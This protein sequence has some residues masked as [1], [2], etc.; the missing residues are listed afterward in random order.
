MTQPGAFAAV[1]RFGLGARAGELALASGDPRGW[2]VAQLQATPPQPSRLAGLATG[3]QN[4]AQF[5]RSRRQGA[6]DA[7]RLIR[8]E[9]RTT[10]LR[11]AVART[12]TQIEAESPFR[13]RLVAF[14]SNHFTV[15]VQRPTLLGL[16]GAFEREAIRPNVTGK[17]RDMLI[18]ATRHPAMLVYLDNALSVGPNSIAGS[19]R[20]R[21]LNEN[22]AREILELHT[23]GVSGGYTQ[24]DVR[25][26]GRI[27]TG[28]SLG[29]TEDGDA[30]HY[31]FQRLIHEPGDK[32][33]LGM[34]YAEAGEDEGVAAL[35]ALAR[36]P[37]TA[38]H[39]ALK[40]ARHFVAD[41]PPAAVVSRL[42]QLFRDSDGDL[43]AL[44]R[45]VIDTPEAWA[46]PLA[47][48]KTPNEFVVSALRATG[49]AG[50]PERLVGSLRVLGQAPFAAPSPA[51]WPDI[52]EQWIG[53]E[54]V[55]RRAE[56]A[57][58]V[59]LRAERAHRP[60]AFFA[61]TIGPVADAATG[62]AIAGAPTA[63][64]G[65]ALVLASAEFQRR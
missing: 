56:W 19:R 52:A 25:E 21:G 24:D 51:G 18:A 11:E 38:T 42:A 28:W 43:A 16:A 54:S 61:A 40:F 30:G 14:W 3:A 20:G 6:A 58:A 9:F 48:V 50:D 17:F 59:A 44:S 15:S 46:N 22:L 37:A 7:Q 60:D 34:R 13:E 23:V 2:L 8:Q 65:L 33:L 63:A 39:I 64:E 31:K 4:M 27:L 35:T 26:F 32:V 47:K 49:F 41:Q 1:N 62:A 36:H 57:M 12:L 29:R 5:Q 10:Y 45:A 55:L 53:P